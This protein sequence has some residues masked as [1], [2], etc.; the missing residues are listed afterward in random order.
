[1]S[2]PFGDRH[3]KTVRANI[4]IQPP[5]GLA[6][7]DLWDRW[8]GGELNGQRIALP[9]AFERVH[10]KD[11]SE[12]HLWEDLLKKVKK[13]LAIDEIVVLDAG[14]KVSQLQIAEIDRY[15]LRLATNFTAGTMFCPSMPG[16]TQASLWCPGASV[17]THA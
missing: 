8:P 10:P 11:P 4:I 6:S 3:C 1:M 14:V 16:K 9:R 13:W 17:G 15:V 7:S 12:K 2:R 5:A